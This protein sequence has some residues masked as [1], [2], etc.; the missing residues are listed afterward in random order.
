MRVEPELMD[1]PKLLRL[2]KRVGDFALE[3]VLRLWG[4][5]QNSQRGGVWRDADPEY[6]EIV[7]RWPGETGVFYRA[8]VEAKFI[9]ESP[10]GVLIHDWDRF[11]SMARASWKNG[12]KGG[13]PP[14]KPDNAQSDLGLTQQEPSKNPQV[15]RGQPMENHLGQGVS[16]SVS[17][18]VSSTKRERERGA[19]PGLEAQKLQWAA[20]KRRLDE[21]G[22]ID[23]K[24]R[25]KEETVELQE[26][27][28][29]LAEIEKNQREGKV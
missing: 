12:S 21:I 15:T 29:K 28:K 9:E 23:F 18:S 22:A 16:Q 17:Q 1:H 8:A 20:I 27:K 26:L 11:N 3:G 24:K 13:R 6:V 7:A 25:T 4:H 14:G 5:C 2:K 19:S 10:K